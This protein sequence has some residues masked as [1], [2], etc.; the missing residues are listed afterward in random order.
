MARSI[1]Q[2]LLENGST[3]ELVWQG[4]WGWAAGE[5]SFGGGTLT[6]QWYNSISSTWNTLSA[7]VTFNATGNGVFYLPQGVHLRFTLEGATS[8][9]LYAIIKS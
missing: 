5:G 6:L 2:Q 9:D 3:N 4:G 7:D 8:P 1:N